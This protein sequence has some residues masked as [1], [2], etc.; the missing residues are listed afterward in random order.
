MNIGIAI[1][2]LR[3]GK[4]ITQEQLAEYLGVS[5]Q[6]VSRWETGTALPD[7]TQVPILANIF[8]VSADELLGIDIAAKEERINAITTDAWENYA[9][10]GRGDEAIAILRTALKEYPN[11][12]KLMQNLASTIWS[13]ADCYPHDSDEYKNAMQ[14]AIALGEVVLAEC[15]DDSIRSNMVQFQCYAYMGLGKLEKAQALAMKMPSK[16]SSC[17]ALWSH[18]HKGTKLYQ[19]KQWMIMSSAEDML[20]DITGHNIKLDDGTTPYTLISE[21]IA[22]QQKCAE[23]YAILFEEENYGFYHLRLSEIHRKIA[24]LN[25][26]EEVNI[27]F[28]LKHLQLA[29]KHAI[30]FDTLDISKEYTSLLFRGKIIG[31]SSKNSTNNESYDLLKAMDNNALDPI[32][33]KAEFIAVE[34]NLRKY[35]KKHK[36]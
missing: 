25:V 14:E 9:A 22:I 23:I 13:Y 32:R 6:A 35:A 20:C 4:D 33:E 19:Y 34:E 8:N 2:K 26:I 18:I 15:T 30:A 17:E 31:S 27:N 16:Y 36:P 24:F 3:R 11:S 1:K 5:A 7:I 28:A 12:Y 29:A 10:K 21:R